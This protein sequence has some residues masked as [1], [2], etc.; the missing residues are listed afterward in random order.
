MSHGLWWKTFREG[1]CP[2]FGRVRPVHLP[3]IASIERR[4]EIRE[5]RVVTMTR[6]QW[7]KAQVAPRAGEYLS[8]HQ[9]YGKVMVVVDRVSLSCICCPTALVF[10]HV[11]EVEGVLPQR[12]VCEC[13]GKISWQDA[14]AWST[15]P[16]AGLCRRVGSDSLRRIS[17]AINQK[18]KGRQS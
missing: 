3:D 10:L 14:A 18:L 13:V 11:A 12:R 5:G 4:Q 16:E 8:L 6:L 9:R 7:A 15:P 17:D 2:D 1:S